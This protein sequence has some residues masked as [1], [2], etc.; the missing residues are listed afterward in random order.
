MEHKL[1]EHRDDRDRDRDEHGNGHRPRT[2]WQWLINGWL[3]W[4]YQQGVS[5]VLL[6]LNVMLMAHFLNR[7]LDKD[8]PE[9][10][11]EVQAGYERIELSHERQIKYIMDTLRETERNRRP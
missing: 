2:W 11:K 4:L 6:I 9:Y 3:L 8:I 5:T 1:A 10:R 7:I